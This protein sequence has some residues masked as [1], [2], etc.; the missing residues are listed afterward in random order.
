MISAKKVSISSD[1]I[2]S[3]FVI[4]EGSS[5][6]SSHKASLKETDF[7]SH[8]GGRTDIGGVS[9][10]STLR[11]AILT[12]LMGGDE[13]GSLMPL[14]GLYMSPILSESRSIGSELSGLEVRRSLSRTI[15]SSLNI[16][17]STA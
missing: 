17:L 8:G 4:G 7:V 16:T 13:G 9:G 6:M 1:E 14:R 2:S 5:G 11:S 10:P 3:G 12:L 15:A